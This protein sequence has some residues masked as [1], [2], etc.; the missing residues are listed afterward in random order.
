MAMAKLPSLCDSA[1]LQSHRVT[2]PVSEPL[3]DPLTP[4]R[5]MRLTF[6]TFMFIMGGVMLLM[7]VFYESREGFTSMAESSGIP[8]GIVGGAVVLVSGAVLFTDALVV[9]V[10]L[11]RR[12]SSS[13]SSDAVDCNT[14]S[15]SIVSS[16]H[17]APVS[18]SF[19]KSQ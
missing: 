16:G 12:S 17:F 15:A 3:A 1:L 9:L 11:I 6:F 13:T 10:H 19:N 14:S 5:L 8:T 2:L 7:R 4:A 18:V